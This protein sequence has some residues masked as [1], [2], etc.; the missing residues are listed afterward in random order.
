M[1]AQGKFAVVKNEW[2]D[3]S[4]DNFVTIGGSRPRHARAFPSKI[5]VNCAYFFTREF[6]CDISSSAA[7]VACLSSRSVTNSGGLRTARLPGQFT[8]LKQHYIYRQD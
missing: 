7:H 6:S 4:W 8:C 5:L 1:G 2:Y 3:R